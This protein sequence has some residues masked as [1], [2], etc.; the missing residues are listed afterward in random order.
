[1]YKIVYN[2]ESAPNVKPKDLLDPGLVQ[3]SQNKYTYNTLFKSV[4]VIK[5]FVNDAI[6][7]R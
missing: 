4:I 2:L 7:R 6:I 5:N 1:M 3:M